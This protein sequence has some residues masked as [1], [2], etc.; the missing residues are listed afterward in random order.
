MNSSPHSFSIESLQEQNSA[1]WE[2][3][4]DELA[5][6]LRVFVQRIGAR[7]PDDI[8]SETMLNIVRDI[9]SFTGSVDQLRPWAFTIARN[10]VIDSA[11]RQK[12]RPEA[13]TSFDTR[14]LADA[15]VGSSD[16][17]DLSWLAEGFAQLTPEQREVLWLRYVM[18]FS[19]VTTSQITGSTPDAVASMAHRALRTLREVL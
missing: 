18:D 14:D 4:Y 13:S 7:D 16:E 6:D 8:V 19:L 2:L 12:R 10:R 1:A 3:L 5:P 11:R 9:K 15:K 17:I